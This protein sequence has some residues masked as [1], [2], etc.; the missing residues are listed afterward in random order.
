MKIPTLTG[1]VC[2][3]VV[4]TAACGGANSA[5][6]T[7][8]L[9]EAKATEKSAE[10]AASSNPQAMLHL[11][12]AQEQ[13][14]RA[15]TLMAEG[16]NRRAD[17]VLLRAKEDAELAAALE[18]ATL[19]RQ[20]ALQAIMLVDTMQSQNH[21]ETEPVQTTPVSPPSPSTPAPG[22]PPGPGGVR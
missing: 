9:V 4:C 5:A 1:L 18:R 19:A 20:E 7:Q 12:L 10:D 2:I 6:P 14:A 11:K 3:S 22:G 13:I 21:Q 8:R 16:D 17:Y 15:E